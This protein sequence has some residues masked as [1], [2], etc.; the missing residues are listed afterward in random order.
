MA[1]ERA[2]DYLYVAQWDFFH[3]PYTVLHKIKL[4]AGI[5]REDF[6]K[7][8][9]EEG[10]PSVGNVTTRVGEVSTQYLLTD[11]I[12]D[13]PSRIE[14]LDLSLEAFGTRTAVSSLRLVSRWS[15]DNDTYT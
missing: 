1:E 15:R 12:E 4:N 13:P 10:F 2:Y 11:T 5:T 6:E 8:M 3:P 7:F 14:E 9:I